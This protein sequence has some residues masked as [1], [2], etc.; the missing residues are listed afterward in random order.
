MAVATQLDLQRRS[1]R[2]RAA[3]EHMQRH[4]HPSR[5][6]THQSLLLLSEHHAVPAAPQRS[7]SATWPLARAAPGTGSRGSH[8]AAPAATRM[9]V[10]MARIATVRPGWVHQPYQYQRHQVPGLGDW[11]DAGAREAQG[12]NARGE[13]EKPRAMTQTTPGVAGQAPVSKAEMQRSCSM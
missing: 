2:L 1:C 9:E 11:T 8:V 7:L 4:P 13:N 6:R 10:D 3:R 12:R 5:S